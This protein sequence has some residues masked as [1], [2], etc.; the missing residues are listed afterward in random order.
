MKSSGFIVMSTIAIMSDTLSRLLLPK[1]IL[2]QWQE[3]I[4]G[5]IFIILGLNLFFSEQNASN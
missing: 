5:S 3:K 2:Y 4:V 1:S